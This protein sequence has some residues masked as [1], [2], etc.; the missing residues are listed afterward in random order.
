MGSFL[1]IQSGNKQRR[2]NRLSKPPSTF[3]S[4]SASCRSPHQTSGV[5]SPV[6]PN[7][8]PWQ[9]SSTV[10]SVSISSP[11]PKSNDRRSQ[12]ILSVSLQSETPWTGINRPGKRQPVPGEPNHVRLDTSH[13]GVPGPLCRRASFQP[14]REPDTLHSAPRSPSDQ[15]GPPRRSYSVHSAA[16]GTRSAIH[17]S[18]LE[19]AASSNTHF[20]I[21]SPGFSLIRR[22]SLLT[23]PGIATRR[24][25]RG[26]AQRCPSP[27]GQE[28]GFSPSCTGESPQLFQ[29]PPIDC[30]D[31]VLQH[32]N[33]LAEVRP[34]TPG[35]FGYTH[36]GALKLGSLRVVN[37]SASPCP[38]DRSRL[39]PSS[40][41]EE[42]SAVH[43]TELR[44]S[45]EYL[46]Q[47]DPSG[48]V[49]SSSL[50][51]GDHQS[52]PEVIWGPVA[53]PVSEYTSDD[54]PNGISSNNGY[55]PNLFRSKPP[56]ST[57]QIPPFPDVTRYEDFPA[58]PFSFE[59]SPI[60]A[61]SH[62]LY[63]KEAEDE[64]IYVSDD[65][66][67][68]EFKRE[69]SQEVP[70]PRRMSH[71]HRKVDSGYSSA[72]SVRSLQD[73]RTRAS[74]DSQEST[75]RP[76]GYRRFTLGGSKSIEL[77]N[78]ENHL[79][80]SQQLPINRHLN[81]QGPR[82][83]PSGV[84]RGWSTDRATMCHEAPQISVGGRP[85]SLSFT[86]QHPGHTISL[87]R[88]CTQLRHLEA[89]SSGVSLP[90][91]HIPDTAAIQ[92]ADDTISA[93]QPCESFASYNSRFSYDRETGLENS[94]QR[95]IDAGINADQS[96]MF[97]SCR[98]KSEKSIVKKTLNV[99]YKQNPQAIVA[100]ADI[101][102][103]ESE[104]ETL[105]A[106]TSQRP[107][108]AVDVGCVYSESLRGRA[109]SRT[110]DIERRMSAK[111]QN[112]QNTYAVISP[113]IYR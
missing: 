90:S 19:E 2:P 65:E 56:T 58:S 98:S 80:L 50:D 102:H 12:S 18:S 43:T 62:N 25:V 26:V 24:S 53:A 71:S 104:I 46:T 36:L 109:R 14:S 89:P 1:S 87:S 63:A 33:P 66:T 94:N 85:R 82:M 67:P 77:C 55:V 59:K 86:S 97:N 69:T 35:D 44:W 78:I 48:M 5:D 74:V 21:D 57:V 7:R 70:C 72:A 23:R 83:S 11:D 42:T 106:P 81:L 47:N 105:V 45:R 76:P 4:R 107:E 29:W 88:Y 28:L 96:Y 60:I 93:V 40:P 8:A 10:A 101:R 100:N 15:P 84:P 52:G 51:M 68:L 64:A 16:Q 38:S 110:L 3:T 13:S 112:Q 30:E 54:G 27:I 31:P 39:R 99:A 103:L 34:P 73:S 75:Q 95:K 108:R 9:D 32:T 113:F 37:G 20:M 22:R 17:Q 92:A 91:K 49:T 79:E 41:A 6:A 61:T 111:Q